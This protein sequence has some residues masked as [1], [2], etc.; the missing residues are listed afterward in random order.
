[1]S[2][3]YIRLKMKPTTVYSS[4]KEHNGSW[5]NCSV[6]VIP[7]EINQHIFLP[8]PTLMNFG[9][10]VGPVVKF[11]YAK[12]QIFTN[13]GRCHWIHSINSYLL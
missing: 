3:K 10:H 8:P 5:T 2:T 1:M 7:Y 4:Y 9:P 11:T 13:I 6:C 12:C